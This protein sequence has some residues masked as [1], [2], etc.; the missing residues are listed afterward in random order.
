M[1]ST[2]TGMPCF[3][4]TSAIGPALEECTITSCPSRC[5]SS[6]TLTGGLGAGELLEGVE[7]ERMRIG[8]GVERGEQ[9]PDLVAVVEAAA[10]VVAVVDEAVPLAA[11]EDEHEVAGPRRA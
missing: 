8:L 11:L 9:G 7:A 5:S 1:W 2:I 3:R 4:A 10:A 6:A